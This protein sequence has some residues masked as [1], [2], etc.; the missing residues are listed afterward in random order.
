MQAEAP[1]LSLPAL[2]DGL[3]ATDYGRALMQWHGVVL[4]LAGRF[5]DAGVKS[6]LEVGF[7]RGHVL[8][9]LRDNGFE[10]MGT[11]VAREP[12]RAMA[13]R[14]HAVYPVKDLARFDAASQ[15]LVLGVNL[16]DHLDVAEAVSLVKDAWRVAAMGLCAVVA[17]D[18]MH[19]RLELDEAN[20]R[21]FFLNTTGEKA[22][23]IHRK[24]AGMT[25]LIWKDHVHTARDASQPG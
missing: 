5:R 13:A 9:S 4:S 15:D 19:R 23:V 21:H 12:I 17:A 3:Y 7:G 24:N 25:F 6:I 16:F 14:G 1:A 22:R 2:Y 8:E 10:V 11:E 18:P 20:W